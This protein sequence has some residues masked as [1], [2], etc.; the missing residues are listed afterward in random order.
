[1]IF[2][3]IKKKVV[4]SRAGRQEDA[5]IKSGIRNLDIEIEKSKSL[6]SAS[7]TGSFLAPNVIA[8]DS[9]T[10]TITFE[11]FEQLRSIRSVYLNYMKS[12]HPNDE[13]FD[14]LVKIGVVLA[15]IHEELNIKNSIKW[16]PSK[17]FRRAFK[18]KTGLDIDQEL[19][20]VP[21]STAHCDFGFSNIRFIETPIGTKDLVIIDPSVNGFVTTNTNL[22]APVYVDLANLLSCICGLVPIRNYRSMYW[23]RVPNL[24]SSIISSYNERSSHSINE[25]VLNGMV[26]ATAKCYF[27]SKYRFPF[28]SLA[29]WLLFTRLKG[30][31]IQQ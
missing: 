19:M 18:N 9:N 21:W 17:L 15:E 8:H 27:N 25:P 1:M 20:S 28:S 14:L 4:K 22:H 11:Y 6:H 23:G 30:S 13:D 5:F 31:T 12:K 7:K 10:N 16:V 3:V 24:I 2:S 29:L 26:F